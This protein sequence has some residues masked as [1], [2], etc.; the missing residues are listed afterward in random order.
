MAVWGYAQGLIVGALSLAGF[1]GGAF[2]G[3]RIGPAVLA[4]GSS[5]PYAPL[6]ALIGAILLGG[7]F[8]SGLEVLGFRL[9]QRIGEPLGVLDGLGGAVLVAALALGF[10]WMAGAVALQTPGARELRKPIQRSVILKELNAVLPP[11]GPIL[12]ALARF[13]PFPQINGPGPNVAPPNAKIARDPEVRAAGRSVVKVLGTAC[14]L[15]VQGSGWL[16][17][18]GVVV[19]NA[20]VVAGQDDTTVQVGGEGP[21]YDTD[22]VWFDSQERRRDAAGARARGLAGAAPERG[23]A[24]RHQ[25]RHPRL[26]EN[27]P[28]DVEPGRLGDTETV[29]TEDAYGRG[30]V[31]RRITVLR[32]LVRPGNSGGPMV[33]GSGRVVTTIF[34]ATVS[35]GAERLRRAGLDRPRRPG[36][37]GAH[38]GH[39][40]LR[41][42]ARP[43]AGARHTTPMRAARIATCLVVLASAAPALAAAATRSQ[44]LPRPRAGGH[45]ALPRPRD[46]AAVRPVRGREDPPHAGAAP[47]RQLDRQ[48]RPRPGRA[49]RAQHQPLVH[50]R[51]PADLQAR[52]RAGSACTPAPGSSSSSPTSTAAGGSSS[53]PRAS[54]SGA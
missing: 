50:A 40:A 9:R 39:R 28:Y 20:H 36:P 47:G 15:G 17:G 25:R 16:A 7:I 37:G 24:A 30:P 33:D 53:A 21:H 49:A 45:A 8:A 22:P 13:D 48:H 42:V 35:G 43:A 31:R 38:G 26:P 54:S 1:V 51:P 2:L 6:F 32:G 4:K 46:A 34:A 10:V 52:W 27:G 18:D 19:T 23:R 29:V 41:Q 3:A 14:G 12:K 11:S 44:P 5:S